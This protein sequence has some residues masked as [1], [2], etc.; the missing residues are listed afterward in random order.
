MY[1]PVATFIQNK[2]ESFIEGELLKVTQEMGL[3]VDR[4]E[5]LKALKYD[6][7]QYEKG[8]R[9]GVKSAQKYG[10]W[11]IRSA[12]LTDSADSPFREYYMECSEC[13]RKVEGISV[14][15]AINY[16]KLC[17]E[18]PYCHCG[19]KMDGGNEE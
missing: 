2:T 7:G 15:D 12:Y 17:R 16:R 10:N 8:F 19:A 18:Y 4:E 1:E 14:E 13:G 6:R 9:D 5:L 11:Y 3:D